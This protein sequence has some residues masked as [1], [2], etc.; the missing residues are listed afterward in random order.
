M[1]SWEILNG[2]QIHTRILNSEWELLSY[3]TVFEL[4]VD[5]IGMGNDDYINIFLN[6]IPEQME[7]N[8]LSYYL[9][10][11]R[12]LLRSEIGIDLLGEKTQPTV[13]KIIDL[14]QSYIF[15]LVKMLL[16]N[17]QLSDSALSQQFAC[18]IAEQLLLSVEINRRAKEPDTQLNP[19]NRYN[20]I[21]LEFVDQVKAR[22]RK[23]KSVHYYAKKLG[24]TV[25][26]LSKATQLILNI[27]PK[28]LIQKILTQ[29]AMNLLEHSDK[30]VKEISYEL[31]IKENNNFSSF[32]KKM[33]NFTPLEYRRVYASKKINNIRDT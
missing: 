12:N 7:Y 17:S 15:Y 9:L 2:E 5:P 19:V 18:N 4:Y 24:V 31:G 10:L 27:T 11:N 14:D 13:V 25:K 22:F 29:E 16:K 3:D 20:L 26:S 8:N 32:F 23:H 1:N 28:D 33:T 30:S 21:A 6:F